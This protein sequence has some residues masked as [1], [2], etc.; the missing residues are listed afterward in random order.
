MSEQKLSSWDEVV[1]RFDHKYLELI[2]LSV[3]KI[4]RLVFKKNEEFKLTED[5]YFQFQHS[6]YSYSSSFPS[7]TEILAVSVCYTSDM[8]HFS[9]FII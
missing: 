3:Q 2:V 4:N 1:T 9:L 5:E 8:G 7:A 6:A